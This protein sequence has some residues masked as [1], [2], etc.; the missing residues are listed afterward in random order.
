VTACQWCGQP[1]TG[2]T[3]AGDDERRRAVT[4]HDCDA[5]CDRSHDAVRRYPH[6]RT[7]L[8]HPAGRKRRRAETVQGPTLLDFLPPEGDTKWQPS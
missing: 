1:A 2:T 3:T 6:R 7:V 5:C 8:L 4:I